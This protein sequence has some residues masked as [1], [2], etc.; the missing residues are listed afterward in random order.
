MVVGLLKDGAFGV[1]VVRMPTPP[2]RLAARGGAARPR[3]A[4]RR[5]R[6]P[7]HRPRYR[8]RT[9]SPARRCCRAS[10]TALV[11]GVLERQALPHAGQAACATRGAER[12]IGLEAQRA[13]LQRSGITRSFPR[14]RCVS[15]C[16]TRRGARRTRSATR[17]A[18]RLR[19]WRAPRRLRPASRSSSS[20]RARRR[21]PE[22]SAPRARLGI[23]VSVCELLPAAPGRTRKNEP[24]KVLLGVSSHADTARDA[25]RSDAEP[26]PMAV[27]T[28]FTLTARRTGSR[29]EER[30]A[31]DA[32]CTSP[33]RRRA[34]ARRCWD[35]GRAARRALRRR[36]PRELHQRPRRG[37]AGMA[38]ARSTAARRSRRRTRTRG[39]ASAVTSTGGLSNQRRLAEG[40]PYSGCYPSPVDHGVSG[41]GLSAHYLASDR[42]QHGSLCLSQEADASPTGWPS[43]T[44]CPWA[45]RSTRWRPCSRA[46]SRTGSTPASTPR[47][48][49]T[50]RRSRR[51]ARMG[52]TTAATTDGCSRCPSRE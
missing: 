46:A 10:A 44:T 8:W 27:I 52:R 49:T 23:G 43:T 45:K 35:P 51:C 19:G 6:R 1:G 11:P 39:S 29:P 12:Y 20:P 4:A 36:Q 26:L 21:A 2:R 16:P 42:R 34:P 22:P 13:A 15:Q 48:P 37:R 40:G 5:V 47:C 50:P 38:A 7:R 25:P 31:F 14:C 24:T 33:R 17:R 18:C 9:A 3:P 28:D 32:D 30:C 41:P